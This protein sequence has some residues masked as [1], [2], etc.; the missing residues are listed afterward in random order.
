[1]RQI[2]QIN[3]DK[4]GYNAQNSNSKLQSKTAQISFWEV[5][6]ESGKKNLELPSNAIKK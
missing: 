3:V 4:C 1:M 5:K 2:K 6:W